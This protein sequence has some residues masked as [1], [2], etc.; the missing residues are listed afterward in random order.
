LLLKFIFTASKIEPKKFEVGPKKQAD[1]MEKETVKPLRGENF[2]DI[3][4]SLTVFE[5]CQF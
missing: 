4:I 2:K 5:L 1:L 3:A